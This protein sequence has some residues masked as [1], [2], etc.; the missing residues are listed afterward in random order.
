MLRQSNDMIQHDLAHLMGVSVRTV[1][2]RETGDRPP[3]NIGKLLN[4]IEK[5]LS[6][7]VGNTS[8]PLKGKG[9]KNEMWKDK[10]ILQMELNQ[11]LQIEIS[12]LLIFCL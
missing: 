10:Y 7:D 9:E 8:E 1:S 12:T 6:P 11:K 3:K 5:L 4:Q 2:G